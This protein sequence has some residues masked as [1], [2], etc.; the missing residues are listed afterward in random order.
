MLHGY[1][2]G[3][4][5][6]AGLRI[7]E[8][9][10]ELGLNPKTLR[11]YE[12]I[13]L[14]PEPDRT[15]SGYRVYRQ[16]DV[17]RLRFIAKA[18]AIGLTLDEIRGI[19]AVRREGQ[20]PCQHVLGLVDDKLDIVDRQLRALADF[21]TELLALRSDAENAAACDGTV[22]S[23]IEQHETTYAAESALSV[24]API[25]QRRSRRR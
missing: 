17:E 24:V 8:I 1:V 6:K 21:R 4:K 12:E 22:C 9:A 15:E 5:S 19:L 20:P 2:M 23:I 16:V 18:K 25:S 13:G 3:R 7:G 14:L 10:G 11:Y